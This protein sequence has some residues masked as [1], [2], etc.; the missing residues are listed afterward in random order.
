MGGVGERMVRGVK[1]GMSALEDGRSV[2]DET[3]LTTLAEV[4]FLINTTTRVS[5]AS[6]RFRNTN[7]K[8]RSPRAFFW[9]EAAHAIVSGS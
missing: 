3:L 1:E 2:N 6:I 9:S 4:E 7:A 8:P 5:A